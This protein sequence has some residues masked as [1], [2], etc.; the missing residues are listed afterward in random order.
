MVMIYN[1]ICTRFLIKTP[2]FGWKAN[3]LN[4]FLFQPYPN[5]D[6]EK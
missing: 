6:F 4:G 2:L 5:I 3:F 1:A